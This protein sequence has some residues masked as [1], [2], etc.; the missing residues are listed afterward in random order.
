MGSSAGQANVNHKSNVSKQTPEFL[1]KSI[2]GKVPLLE[3]DDVVIFESRAICRYLYQ[4]Y[5][6]MGPKLIPDLSNAEAMGVWEMRLILEA[7][8][9]DA[10][11]DA[12]MSETFIKP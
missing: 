7:I 1:E 11:I 9:F 5:P 12:V 10:N 8:E 6:D 4:K 2:F 3:A